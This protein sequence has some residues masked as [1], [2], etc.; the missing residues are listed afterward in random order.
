MSTPSFMQKTPE[1]R[2]VARLYKGKTIQMWEGKVKIDDIKGWAENPRIELFR[3]KWLRDYHGQ[4]PGQ[5]DVYEIMKTER[6]MELN[7]LRDNI[8]KNDLR[9]PL[10]LTWKGKLLDGNRRFFAIRY[11]LET[12]PKDHS[13]RQN[14][15]SVNVFVLTKESSSEDEQRILVEE[16]FA[17]SL[18]KEWPDYVKA[19]K[20]KEA[21]EENGVSKADIA[22]KF[23]WTGAKVNET[24]RIL[25]I[26]DEYKQFAQDEPDPEDESGGGLG[27]SESEIEEEVSEK[28]QHFNEAQKSFRVPLQQDIAFKLDFFRWL[29]E[30]KFTSFAQ[31]RAAYKAW[32]NPEAKN[33]LDNQKVDA[34]K[35]AKT[36]VDDAER[37]EKKRMKISYQVRH[38]LDFLRGLT[39]DDVSELTPETLSELQGI[40]MQSQRLSEMIN[41]LHD[42]NTS[43]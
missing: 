26:V 23:G 36:V 29:H 21:H 35:D 34:G 40:L 11:A 3:S 32:G 18:K 38:F 33:I 24:M 31:V 7:K 22:E 9:E 27:L 25:E 5:D 2:I 4:E 41:N 20:I 15:D 43:D 42:G 30:G 37:A 10:V 28:Y 8:C 16:N 13:A 19:I 12:L 1:P 17:P 14:L 6:Q 39:M